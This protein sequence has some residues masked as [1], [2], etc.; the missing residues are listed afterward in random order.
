MTTWRF[1][2]SATARRMKP[3]SKR[4]SPSRY[5]TR[6]FLSATSTSASRALFCDTCSPFWA[7]TLNRNSR[8]P[9]SEAMNVTRTVADSPSGGSL[10]SCELTIRPSSSTVSWTVDPPYPV[11][12]TKTSTDNDVPLRIE[13][14]V[15]TRVT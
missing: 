8:A 13:R 11:W 15:S 1:L 4:G 6:S 5:S 10:T 9:A 3:A 14:G 2:S 7:A 12:L